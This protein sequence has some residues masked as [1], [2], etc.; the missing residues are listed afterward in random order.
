MRQSTPWIFFAC[1]GVVVKNIVFADIL[2]ENYYERLGVEKDAEERDIRSAF[3]KKALLFHPDKNPNDEDANTKM[4]ELNLALN[5]LTNPDLRKGYDAD[6]KEGVEKAKKDHGAQEEHHNMQDVKF[7]ENFALY[8]DDKQIEVMN[9]IQWEAS[10]TSTA[11]WFV[12]FYSS[13]CTHCVDMADNW[14]R[15]GDRFHGMMHVAAVNCD[16]HFQ[17]CR[18]AG[19]SSLPSIFMWVKGGPR[20]DKDKVEFTP[21]EQ[22]IEGYSYDALEAFAVKFLP[23]EVRTLLPQDYPGR[24]Q[25]PFNGDK[26]K[27]WVVGFCAANE[28]DNCD[29]LTLRLKEIASIVDGL[30]GVGMINCKGFGDLCKK[31]GY[32]VQESKVVVFSDTQ[33]NDNHISVS[34]KSIAFAVMQNLQALPV[35]SL[36]TFEEVAENA[37]DHQHV[38]KIKKPEENAR[39]YLILFTNPATCQHQT[40]L[41]EGT[42]VCWTAGTA[43]RKVMNALQND[44]EYK[45]L[46]VT[47]FN[48]DQAAQDQD[49]RVKRLCEEM[50]IPQQGDEEPSLVLLKD[51]ALN[52]LTFVNDIKHPN[53][54]M[55]F[56]Q[57][58]FGSVVHELNQE[59]IDVHITEEK[60]TWFVDFNAPWCHHCRDVWPEWNLASKHYDLPQDIKIHFGKVNCEQNHERCEAMHVRSYPTFLLFHEGV[61]HQFDFASRT[62]EEFVRFIKETLEPVEHEFTP[63]DYRTMIFDPVK[64]EPTEPD[65]ERWMLDFFA[66]WC[67]HCTVM[68]PKY[69]E[70]ASVLRGVM[71]FGKLNCELEPGFCMQL[72]IRAYPTIWRFDVGQKRNQPTARYPGLPDPKMILNFAMDGVPDFVQELTIDNFDEE[73]KQEVDSMSWVV[74]FYNSKKMTE[75]DERLLMKTRAL[76]SRYQEKQKRSKEAKPDPAFLKDATTPVDEPHQVLFGKFDCKASGTA[77]TFCMKEKIKRTPMLVFYSGARNQQS[78]LEKDDMLKV[79][80]DIDKH[81]HD[82][83]REIHHPYRE[84]HRFSYHTEL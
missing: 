26:G 52:A 18:A 54:V 12:N 65:R 51:G 4:V 57:E 16:Q 74:V 10:H 31:L 75:A 2:P 42:S 83:R 8:D 50:H 84:K 73:V 33:K 70:A 3:K 1:L 37:I 49:P 47:T 82:D 20:S 21:Q 24:S 27:D 29:E 81:I 48:C 46:E 30:A 32:E 14:R 38:S 34:A 71:K 56:V 45:E 66:P 76:A 79:I 78:I 58:N 68:S 22:G 41:G 62:A 67:S 60:Q 28:S 63:D 15:V 43:L 72:G 40:E 53:E 19:V 55:A 17:V 6:G 35:L 7:F 64:G 5:V 59:D 44:W 25:L 77:F 39:E 23:N 61:R 69:R 80:S 11:T 13:S 9:Y 36:K